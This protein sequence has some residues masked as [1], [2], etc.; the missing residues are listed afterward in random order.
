MKAVETGGRR[1]AGFAL[2]WC[3]TLLG[4]DIYYGLPVTCPMDSVLFP[5][6]TANSQALEDAGIDFCRGHL[7]SLSRAILNGIPVA[8]K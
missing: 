8:R 1:M 7:Q 3:S 5:T 4:C 2:Q 6:R